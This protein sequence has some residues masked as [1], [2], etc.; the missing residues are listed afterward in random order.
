MGPGC[1]FRSLTIFLALCFF[2]ASVA[3]A[4]SPFDNQPIRRTT[5][6][7]STTT[8]SVARQTSSS[9]DLPRLLIAT[10]LVIALIFGA[11]WVAQKFLPSTRAG[12]SGPVRLI[13]R[14]NIGARQQILLVQVGQRL[15][16]LS[17]SSGTIS[18][19]SELENPDEIALLMGSLETS[20]EPGRF[21]SLFKREQDEFDDEPMMEPNEEVQPNQ[22]SEPNPF[23]SD[24]KSLLDRVKDVSRQMG[25]K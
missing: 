22:T 2:C 7:T 11:R 6:P 5:D 10:V 13:S 21:G 3:H 18:R 9:V 1:H 15:L 16:I 12:S 14:T 23:E 25:K 8:Q 17:D 4:E 20:K 19:L 24:L